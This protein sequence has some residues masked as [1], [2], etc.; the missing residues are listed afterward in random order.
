MSERPASGARHGPGPG[1]RLSTAFEGAVHP[2]PAGHLAGGLLVRQRGMAAVPAH[3][4]PGRRPGNHG[5]GVGDGA[6]PPGV[7][8]CAGAV[9]CRA[10][11]P[12]PHHA[13][14]AEPPAPAASSRSPPSANSPA[15]G[16]AAG[17]SSRFPFRRRRAMSGKCSASRLRW[18]GFAP[19]FGARMG[20]PAGPLRG[21]RKHLQGLWR[22]RLRHLPHR[23]VQPARQTA[24]RGLVSAGIQGTVPAL[25]GKIHCRG[26]SASTPERVSPAEAF[27]VRTE[28][29][30]AWRAFPWSDP[31]LPAELLPEAWPRHEAR[32]PL[33]RLYDGLARGGHGVRR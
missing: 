6:E 21:T 14:R 1:H 9:E 8:G 3:R 13:G 15:T 30:D 10:D 4:C 29:M 18:R 28:L 19:L 20:L 16:T 24:R 11:V 12:L 25:H 33:V 5:L 23:G 26:R 32:E 27:R 22:G 2:A 17:P 31:D 7:P